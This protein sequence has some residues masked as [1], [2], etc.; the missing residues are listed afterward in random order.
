MRLFPLVL[1]LVVPVCAQ[2][3]PAPGGRR[4]GGSDD[5]INATTFSSLRVRNICPSLIS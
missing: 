5:P 1:C 4:G 3:E 2:D